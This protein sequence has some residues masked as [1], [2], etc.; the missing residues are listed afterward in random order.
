MSHTFLSYLVSNSEPLTPTTWNPYSAVT[1]VKMIRKS[2]IWNLLIYEDRLLIKLDTAA[3]ESHQAPMV[4]LAENPNLVK[5]MIN[6][7]DVNVVGELDSGDGSV[8]KSA[9]EDLRKAARAGYRRKCLECVYCI[10]RIMR[11]I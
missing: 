6:A 4:H 10:L 3:N 11:Y 8:I 2:S 5:N 7:L 1:T 9:L